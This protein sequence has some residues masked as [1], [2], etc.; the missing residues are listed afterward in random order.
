MHNIKNNKTT[1]HTVEQNN[2]AWIWHYG[3][4]IKD[5]IHV[6]S[7]IYPTFNLQIDWIAS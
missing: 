3:V 2:H 1:V 6:G 4:E 5:G 7:S